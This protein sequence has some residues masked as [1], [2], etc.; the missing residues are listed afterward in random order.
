MPDEAPDRAIAAVL[1]ATVAAPQVRAWPL[2]GPW[3]PNQMNRLTLIA[4]VAALAAA[5]IGGAI[6][7]TAGRLPTT[8]LA[9]TGLT[10]PPT[11]RP[12]PESGAA[13]TAELIGAWY[14]GERDVPGIAAKAGTVLFLDSSTLRFTQA[15]QQETALLRSSASI[16]D[17]RLQIVSQSAESY[18]GGVTC[19]KGT[20]GLYDVATSASGHSL[21]VQRYSDPCNARSLVLAGTW[22]KKACW[23]DA[24]CYGDLDAGTYG[25]QYFDPRVDPA[26]VWAPN[27]GGLTFQ[28]G[29]GWAIAYDSPEEVRLLR[30]SDYARERG[31]TDPGDLAILTVFRQPFPKVAGRDCATT[32][33]PP[34]APL[35]SDPRSPADIVSFLQGESWIKTSS[36]QALTIDGH[37]AIS[38]DLAVN[39]AAPPGCPGER[40]PS[41]EY[42]TG[43]GPSSWGVGL[44]GTRRAR[45]VVI[46][47]G[48]GDV[49]GVV[50]EAP[51]QVSF[52]GFL[53]DAMTVLN[54]FHFE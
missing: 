47:I 35:L 7:L 22:W 2:V 31:G 17:D 20:T 54:T 53:A 13:L 15:N 11:A 27:Y 6:L 23:N 33:A 30:S 21:T 24:A 42:L 45:M 39:A 18:A 4:A 51:D 3:R 38:V 29:S 25:T 34:G 12:T 50:I 26:G 46:D 49:V 9:P 28:V 36:P 14:G 1:Q 16:V 10:S 52:D 40:G 32:T 44:S 37:D 5:V 8:T 41:G 43:Y 48:D 19:P